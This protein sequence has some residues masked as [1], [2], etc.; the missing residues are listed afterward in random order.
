M[1]PARHA[2]L[3]ARPGLIRWPVSSWAALSPPI[4]VS[5]VIVTTTVA[6]TP[7]ACGSSSVG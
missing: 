5:R 6:E 7:P 3:R 1:I 4:N 2:N